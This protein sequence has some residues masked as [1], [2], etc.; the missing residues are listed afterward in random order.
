ML[1]RKKLLSHFTF[2]PKSTF[3]YYYNVLIDRYQKGFFIV[4]GRYTKSNLE[5]VF[6]KNLLSR[7][8][9]FIQCYRKPV[10]DTF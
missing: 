9:I 7:Q 1:G 2:V 4:L 6:P 8:V 3:Q 5:N 10:V